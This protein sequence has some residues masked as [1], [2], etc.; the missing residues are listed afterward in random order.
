[1][2]ELTKEVINVLAKEEDDKILKEVLDYYE[3]LKWRNQRE[4]ESKA[5]KLG[6]GQIPIQLFGDFV[7]NKI[8][9][10]LGQVQPLFKGDY[11]LTNLNLLYPDYIC[12][13]L[14]EGIN[15]FDSKI[16]GFARKDAIIAGVESRT[17]SPVRIIRNEEFVS[18]IDGI[19]P[20]GEG[21]GYAGGITTSAI[22]GI[23]VF[24]KIG[25]K[26]NC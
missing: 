3:F 6:K 7:D 18:N 14:K 19:Y 25:K 12:E 20:C 1:M 4:L 17:S 9:T 5:Y 8:S 23:K 10:S 16:N 21:A 22:D 2:S 15:Y 24:E 11:M 13:A 26:Y